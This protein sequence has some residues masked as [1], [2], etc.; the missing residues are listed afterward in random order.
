MPHQDQELTGEFILN[1]EKQPVTKALG[2]EENLHFYSSLSYHP[3][4]V[5]FL[6]DPR[7]DAVRRDFTIN[8]LF[9]KIPSTKSQK[10]NKSQAPNP[11]DRNAVAGRQTCLEF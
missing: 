9:M 1:N 8:G 10:S 5:K 11:N 6:C 2:E 3:K 4:K 7:E